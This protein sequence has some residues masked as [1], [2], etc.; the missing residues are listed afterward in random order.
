VFT[1]NPDAEFIAGELCT[2]TVVASQVAD[3]DVV[4]PPDTMAAGF[5]ATFTALVLVPIHDIQG[6]THLSPKNGQT[7][8][9]ASSVVTALRTV[10][11]TRGFYVQDQNPDADDSTSEGLFVFTGSSSNPAALVS[12]GDVVQVGGRVSEFRP[13]T[14]NLTITELVGPLTVTTVSSGNALPAL[15]VIGTGGRVRR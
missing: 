13:S 9:T 8:I 4:D 5:T 14:T 7:L 2:L 10:G 3:Q 11:S 1:L 15:T 12:V 6:A